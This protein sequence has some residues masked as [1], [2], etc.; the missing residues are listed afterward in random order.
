MNHI[1]EFGLG[2]SS[3]LQNK[4]RLVSVS[5]KI[6]Q[7]RAGM[8]AKARPVRMKARHWNRIPTPGRICNFIWR[9][10]TFAFTGEAMSRMYREGDRWRWTLS[11]RVCERA[12]PP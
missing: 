1:L 9:F 4:A 10:P 2:Q 6:V 8:E 11:A 5:T 3:L 7:A 12:P